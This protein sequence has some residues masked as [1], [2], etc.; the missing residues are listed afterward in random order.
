MIDKNKLTIAASTV[1]LLAGSLVAKP[2]GGRAG[3]P[4]H[5]PDPETVVADI[6]AGYDAN[7][8]NLISAVELENAL[9][10]LHEKRKEEMAARAEAREAREADRERDRSRRG[11]PEG[12]RG[13]RDPAVVAERLMADFDADGSGNLNT[14]ELLAAVETMGPKGGPRGKRG[15]RGGPGGRPPADDTVE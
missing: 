7:E 10:G 11:G 3:G 4:P 9:V 6:V 1:A 12:D 14:E 8:D 2:E 15:P 5:P 13:P